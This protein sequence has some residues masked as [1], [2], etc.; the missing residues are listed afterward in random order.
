MDELIKSV[1]TQ[2][3]LSEV[4]AQKA[5]KV[6]ITFIKDKLPASLADQVDAVL[7]YPNVA[8]DAEEIL[9]KGI[10]QFEGK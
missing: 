10:G 4:Q 8:T 1:V 9:K 2:T 3:G 6:V 7:N 5:A